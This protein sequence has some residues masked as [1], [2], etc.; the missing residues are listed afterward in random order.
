MS[1]FSAFSDFQ[2]VDDIMARYLND[3][4]YKKP[5][6]DRFDPKSHS[7]QYLRDDNK[8]MASC[9]ILRFTLSLDK[10]PNYSLFSYF[11][12][13]FNLK[14]FEALIQFSEHFFINHTVN[15]SMDDYQLILNKPKDNFVFTE[16]S[17]FLLLFGSTLEI[18]QLGSAKYAPAR[19]RYTLKFNSI[20]I[21]DFR[22]IHNFD[23]LYSA[24]V[25]GFILKFESLYKMSFTQQNIKY[26]ASISNIKY[27]IDNFF[28][29]SFFNSE[30]SFKSLID[31][32]D[33][34]VWMRKVIDIHKTIVEIRPA[35][36]K[37]A[38]PLL[39]K[40]FEETAM[41]KI[42]QMFSAIIF[43][44]KKLFDTDISLFSFNLFN[45]EQEKN[46]SSICEVTG[47]SCHCLSAVFELSFGQELT[48][49]IFN[50]ETGHSK[51]L[52]APD[53]DELYTEIISYYERKI[54]KIT[55]QTF[56]N[57]DTLKLIDMIVI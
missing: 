33:I 37:L 29:P 1:Y 6:N 45:I 10:T 42:R 16:D 18:Q 25:K 21:D 34:P 40:L 54:V 48:I 27:N 20:V 3:H 17:D 8:R 36:L 13:D 4:N 30:F 50:L 23:D 19:E 47:K 38:N 57:N 35:N 53:L 15:N 39:K 46:V 22:D 2:R 11:L 31:L 26:L 43:F 55:G 32:T 52:S 5:A 24:L 7:L 51:T 41:P 56:I 14:Q 9:E 28:N 49:K 44:S 12:D